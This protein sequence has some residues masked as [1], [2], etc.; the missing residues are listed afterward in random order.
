MVIHTTKE[1]TEPGC[2]IS[3][4]HGHD[5]PLCGTGVYRLPELDES[6]LKGLGRAPGR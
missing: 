4:P 5:C 1:C 3:Y 6:S 2:T